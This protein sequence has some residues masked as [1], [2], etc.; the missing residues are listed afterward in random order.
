MGWLVAGAIGAVVAGAALA[1][2]LVVHAGRTPGGVDTWYYLAYARA[3]RRRPSL[4]VR[5]PQY[6]LQDEVQSYPPVF[7]SILALLP[8]RWL[9]RWYWV[10][11]PLVDCAHLLVLYVVTFRL[12]GSVVVAAIAAATYAF[13]PHLISE[14]RSLSGRTFGALLHTLAIL[15]LLKWTLSGTSD[16][17]WAVA[18][19]LAGA[20][21]FLSSAAMAAAYGFVCVSLTVALVDARYGLLACAALGLAFVLSG[22]TNGARDRELPVLRPVLAPQSPALWGPPRAPFAALR[23]S[24]GATGVAGAR[25]PRPIG[26]VSLRASP[27]RESIPARSPVCHARNEALGARAL[28]LGNRARRSF[29]HRN[30]GPTPSR[31]RTRPQLPEGGDLPHRLHPRV[32]NRWPFGPAAPLRSPRPR[33]LGPQHGGD[34]VLRPLRASPVDRADLLGARGPGGGDARARRAARR[35]RSSCCPT[36]TPTTSATGRARVW[37][38]AVTAETSAVSNGSRPCSRRPLPEMFDDLRVRYLLLD[39]HYAR[40][41]DLDLCGR[42]QTLCHH[43]GFE[44][45]EYQGSAAT[46]PGR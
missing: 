15:L 2:R 39:D 5:L 28:R 38:G 45:F 11:S 22:G 27:G 30:R 14:A 46:G 4:D 34:R 12:T 43:E 13:T 17:A 7:P 24:R 25:F 31:L 6:L 20:L 44:V 1:V 9:D 42:V 10:L 21:L 40:P 3:V 37:S 18:A 26:D 36:C 8:E 35:E 23:R 29:H 33:L 16:P 32:S 19:A 41:E